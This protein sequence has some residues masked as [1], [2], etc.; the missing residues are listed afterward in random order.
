[1]G[2]GGSLGPLK[3]RAD[4]DNYWPR[5]AWGYKNQYTIFKE[6]TFNVCTHLELCRHC[7]DHLQT[8][9][10]Q[11]QA[12]G[13]K[14]V[15]SWGSPAPVPDVPVAPTAAECEG[16]HQGGSSWRQRYFPLLHGLG[17]GDQMHKYNKML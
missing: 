17:K 11:K 1:M 3:L 14:W 15:S 9:V 12:P 7:L 6:T 2:L 5:D 8:Q 16:A 13:G 4:N 10:P